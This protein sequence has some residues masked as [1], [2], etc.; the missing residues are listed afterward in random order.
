MDFVFFEYSGAA[1]KAAL[2][3]DNYSH[4]INITREHLVFFVA[5][6]VLVINGSADLL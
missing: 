6:E 5:A 3:I 1:L 2:I 4:R